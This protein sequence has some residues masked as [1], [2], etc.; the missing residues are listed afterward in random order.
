MRKCSL[1]WHVHG[2]QFP[3][4]EAYRRTGISCRLH[5]ER[6][7]VTIMFSDV[8]DFGESGTRCL[9]ICPCASDFSAHRFSRLVRARSHLPPHPF[10]EDFTSIS[11]QLSPTDLLTVLYAYLTEMTN[12]VERQQGVVAEVGQSHSGGR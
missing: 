5:V 1:S 6:R 2:L 9:R 10:R 7:R 3:L 12:I 11:E 4:T 8:K